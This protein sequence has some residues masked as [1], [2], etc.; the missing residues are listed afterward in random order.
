MKPLTIL[1]TNLTEQRGRDKRVIAGRVFRH[2]DP[3]PPTP[4]PTLDLD[5]D[6]KID[7]PRYRF[8][9]AEAATIGSRAAM[10]EIVIELAMRV[11]KKMPPEKQITLP[12]KLPDKRR[13]RDYM[14]VTK[15]PHQ[16]ERDRIRVFVVARLGEK[17]RRGIDALLFFE[18]PLPGWFA[19]WF[20]D[21]TRTST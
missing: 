10:I 20:L 13:T 6:R 19:R 11:Q 4:T 18:Q 14:G 15:I 9:L 3:K 8:L 1:H 7:S 12:T 17:V 16:R 21:F 5:R 2:S